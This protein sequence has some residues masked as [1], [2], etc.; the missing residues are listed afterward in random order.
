MELARRHPG[1][2]FI[3]AHTGGDWERGIRIIRDTGNISADRVEIPSGLTPGQRVIT[4]GAFNVKDGDKVNVT[5]IN[6]E[7]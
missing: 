5:R 7:K 4:R 3:C 1:A 2:N 6:G